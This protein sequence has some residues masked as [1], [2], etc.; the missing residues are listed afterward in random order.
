MPFCDT[1]KCVQRVPTAGLI[2]VELIVVIIHVK[3]LTWSLPTLLF[4][5]LGANPLVRLAGSPLCV[6]VVTGMH[7]A[8]ALFLKVYFY[9]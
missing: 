8:L 5:I 6:S 4:S 7:G 2:R 9:S 3:N 1:A